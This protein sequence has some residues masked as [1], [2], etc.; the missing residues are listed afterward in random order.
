MGI[1]TGNIDNIDKGKCPYQFS[2]YRRKFD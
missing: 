1:T 2:S